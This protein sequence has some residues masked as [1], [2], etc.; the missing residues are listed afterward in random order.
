MPIKPG[1]L[2]RKLESKFGFSPAS[3]K[4]RKKDHIHLQ[5]QFD[6]LPIIVI[7]ISRHTKDIGDPLLGRIS[8]QLRVRRPFFDGMISCTNSKKDYYNKLKQNPYP[9]WDILVV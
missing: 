5:Y 2:K 7:K 3:K 9:P 1:E 8:K 4:S 6:D